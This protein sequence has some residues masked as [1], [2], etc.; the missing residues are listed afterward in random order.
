MKLAG[1]A[2]KSIAIVTLVCSAQ[3]AMAE[4]A[5]WLSD[6]PSG[7][8][9]SADNWM[10]ATV[11][12][13]PS[14]IATFASSNR[15]AVTLFAPTEVESIVFDAGASAYTISVDPRYTLTVGGTGITNNSGLAQ[16]FVTS[17]HKNERGLIVFTNSASAGDGNVFTNNGHSESGTPAATEF[18]NTA[19]AGTSTFINSDPGFDL[20]DGGA[21][22]FF[23]HSSA[24]SATIIAKGPRHNSL[25]AFGS[26][27]VFADFATAANA[28]LIA[29][30]SVFGADASA[31][32]S[33]EN[34]STAG[35]SN[36]LI[37]AGA[38]KNASPGHLDFSG[39]ATA[40][41]AT[42]QIEGDM[43]G[44]AAFASFRE[45]STAGNATIIVGGDKNQVNGP[46]VRFDDSS[47]G[48]TASLKFFGS[49]FLC[50]DFHPPSG[51]SV[52][53]IEGDGMIEMDLPLIVGTNNRSTTFSG[54]IRNGTT[55]T[56]NGALVKVGTGTLTLT[57][58]N[59]YPIGTTVEEG[60]LL[61]S[62]SS[63]NSATGL[64]PVTIQAGIFGGSGPISG[65]VTVGTGSGTGAFLAPA[66]GTT[67]HKVLQLESSLTL[68][69]D[70]TYTVTFNARGSR[71]RTDQVVA[72]GVTISNA[73]IAIEGIA[74]GTLTTG[75]VITLIS[76]VSTNPISGTFSNLPE[77]AIVTVNGNNL[78][79]SYLGGDGNDLTLTVQ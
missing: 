69:S 74:Q 16:N 1:P 9:N 50:L 36:I 71:V 22:E 79:A 67:A 42:I 56:H 25:D 62:T 32:I 34:N 63:G 58:A 66:A 77:G 17:N 78:K 47:S 26:L 23:D 44:G 8:W 35:R 65:A 43:P 13:G 2:M 4:S 6:P 64:G 14:D 37:E 15:T 46:S 28:T 41:D 38:R 53:S 10:P 61:A 30:G 55:A 29:E 76:N 5:T 72:N 40:G 49:G 68:K 51:L 12:N 59:T 75:T 70:A 54:V 33:F 7:D 24:A 18:F 52:G 21:T 73:T 60:T 3:S 45:T 19:N 27:T 57:G 20:S 39:N 31:T 48:G 11:P